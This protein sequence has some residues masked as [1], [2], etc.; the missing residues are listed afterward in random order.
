MRDGIVA[1]FSVHFLF[2][3]GGGAVVVAG[4]VVIGPLVFEADVVPTVGLGVG[5]LDLPPGHWRLLTRRP[6]SSSSRLVLVGKES[7]M[8]NFQLSFPLPGCLY[9]S[10]TAWVASWSPFKASFSGCVLGMFLTILKS[11]FRDF[12]RSSE[13]WPRSSERL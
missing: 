1:Y 13:N 8:W 12:S 3:K 2:G 7:S 9:L 5:A 4:A 6:I 11:V 10:T